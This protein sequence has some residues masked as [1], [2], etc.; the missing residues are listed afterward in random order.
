[1]IY[2][3]YGSN[4][5]I[6]HMKARCPKAK[7]LGKFWLRS[8]R[9]V[10]RGVADC[11]HAPGERIPGVLWKITPECEAILDRKEG[12]LSGAYRKIILPL[13]GY[14]GEDQVMLYVM[15]SKGIFPPS[16]DY[17]RILRRGYKDFGL[18]TRYLN[19]ALAH[20]WDDKNPSHHERQRYM[21]T[22]RPRLAERVSPK[23]E[24]PGVSNTGNLFDYK[25]ESIK[26][27]S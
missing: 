11:I 19:N 27:D 6:E 13:N 18:P 26:C 12:I 22:G 5:S 16:A 25:M 24:R 23:G 14:P 9:L 17:L 21:R 20:A 4:T 3:G 10:F 7:P 2:F 15:N 1:M 8:A